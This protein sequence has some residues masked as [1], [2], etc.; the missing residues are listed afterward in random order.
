MVEGRG[1]GRARRVADVPCSRTGGRVRGA[2]APVQSPKVRRRAVGGPR[3]ARRRQVHRHHLQAPRRFRDIRLP[4]QRLRH[5]RR[6]TLRPGPRQGAGRLLPQGRHEARVL[7]LP[8]PGLAPPRRL[9][10]RLG[11]PGSDVG[12]IRDLP[13]GEGQAPGAGAPDAV[14]PRGDHLVRHTLLDQPRTEPGA[15]RA[16]TTTFSP[17]AW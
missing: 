11:L 7:P 10:K 5:R 9:R 8:R 2:G 16:C 17:T 15:R 13:G 12:G 3:E 1:G 4:Q 6:H 14:R